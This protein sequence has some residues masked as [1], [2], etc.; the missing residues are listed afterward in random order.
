MKLMASRNGI[1]T[2][3]CSRTHRTHEA[4]S[5]RMFRIIPSPWLAPPQFLLTKHELIIRLFHRTIIDIQKYILIFTAA[6]SSKRESQ[7]HPIPEF[8]EVCNVP[9]ATWLPHCPPLPVAGVTEL[10]ELPITSGESNFEQ[11][12]NVVRTMAL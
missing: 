7:F 6:N 3:R 2:S 9:G 8:L 12:W 10:G 1:I 11:Q 5:T 4:R